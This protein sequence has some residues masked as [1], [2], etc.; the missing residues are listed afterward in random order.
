MSNHLILPNKTKTGI[1]KSNQYQA[2]SGRQR[3][4][5]PRFPH[6]VFSF[7]DS[8]FL[9]KTIAHKVRELEYPRW[10]GTRDSTIQ[11]GEVLKSPDQ[12]SQ[13]RSKRSV[14]I[15]PNHTKL[16]LNTTMEGLGPIRSRLNC[17]ICMAIFLGNFLKI[18]FDPF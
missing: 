13:I 16:H 4:R 6:S 9:S 3:P 12:Y 17:I 15:F 14:S 7:W 10:A 18:I 8:W 2:S 1:R 11:D 5:R